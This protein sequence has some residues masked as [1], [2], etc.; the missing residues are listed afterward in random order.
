MPVHPENIHAA[1]VLEIRS[2]KDSVCSGQVKA[3]R[4]TL[5]E[6]FRRLFR[7]IDDCGG[8]SEFVPFQIIIQARTGAPIM[9]VGG[10]RAGTDD[11][12]HDITGTAFFHIGV[13][14]GIRRCFAGRAYRNGGVAA[15]SVF[16][17]DI[18]RRQINQ[19]TVIVAP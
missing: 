19:I 1:V 3:R 18:R 6:I 12:I 7:K 2:R 15:P 4:E 9:A 11:I 8:I 13:P 14:I 17:F 16:A 5:I 10:S